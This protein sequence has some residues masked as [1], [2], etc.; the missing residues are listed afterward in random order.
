MGTSKGATAPMGT[1]CA[2][3]GSLRRVEWV[4]CVLKYYVRSLLL[5]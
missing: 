5:F 2:K 3:W 4:E 1:S